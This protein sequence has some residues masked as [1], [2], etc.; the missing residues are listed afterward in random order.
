MENP[1][2]TVK[3]S[4]GPVTNT[5]TNVVIGKAIE[6]K[7]RFARRRDRAMEGGDIAQ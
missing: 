4:C 6:K 7:G 5:Y 3:R 1:V 2:K